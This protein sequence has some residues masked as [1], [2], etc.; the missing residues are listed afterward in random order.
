MLADAPPLFIKVRGT[1]AAVQ[2]SAGFRASSFGTG[3]SRWD[4]M[5]PDEVHQCPSGASRPISAVDEGPLPG[6]QITDDGGR[7]TPAGLSYARTLCS[8]D[9][10]SDS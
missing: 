7:P 9:R 10:P 4:R 5:L 1:Q 6:S 2:E 3:M 8:G